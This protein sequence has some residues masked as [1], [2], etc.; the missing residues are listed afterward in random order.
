MHLPTLSVSHHLIWIWKN[1]VNYVCSKVVIP[2]H[3]IA[4]PGILWC[5]TTWII[6]WDLWRHMVLR[7]TLLCRHLPISKNGCQNKRRRTASSTFSS[8]YYIC[9]DMFDPFQL[10]LVVAH[11]R[12]SWGWIEVSPPPFLFATSRI[13]PSLQ[14]LRVR[15][16]GRPW[17]GKAKFEKPSDTLPLRKSSPSSSSSSSS[18]CYLRPAYIQSRVLSN[19]SPCVCSWCQSNL[20][21]GGGPF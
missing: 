15:R 4:C 13:C 19:Q 10:R 9:R 5:Q 3:P 17:A 18:S 12:G 20:V 6:A 16:L 8:W 21:Y 2:Q 1:R 14:L 11:A 7:S